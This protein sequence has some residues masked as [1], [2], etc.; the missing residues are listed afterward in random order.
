M[1][2]LYIY[3]PESEL[4]RNMINRAQTEM[5]SYITVLDV[6]NISLDLKTLV[7][8]TPCLIIIG[9]HLQGSQLLDEVNGQLRVTGELA[10]FQEEEDKVVRNSAT[11]RI[12][13]IINAEVLVRF[14]K[15]E[16]LL[17]DALS[18]LQEKEVI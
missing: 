14:A 12:D 6:N 10:K 11:Y 9:D 7:G 5:A 4:E 18:L 8:A 16:Q 3:N 17:A 2:A 15:K 1:K 13:N